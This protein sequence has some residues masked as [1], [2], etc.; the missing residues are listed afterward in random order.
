[1]GRGVT[2]WRVWVEAPVPSL[3][4]LPIEE[5]GKR[6][7][8]KPIYIQ[9]RVPLQLWH[10][11]RLWQIEAGRKELHAGPVLSEA[12]QEKKEA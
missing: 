7:Q 2:D 6:S 4:Q 9:R 8:S 11:A 10:Q 1:M 5:H 3:P 12:R